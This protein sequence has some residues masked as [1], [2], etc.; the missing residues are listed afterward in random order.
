MIVAAKREQRKC[1][2]QLLTLKHELY[3]KSF[4]LI[5]EKYSWIRSFL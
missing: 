5:K 4:N 3:A 1:I 2:F